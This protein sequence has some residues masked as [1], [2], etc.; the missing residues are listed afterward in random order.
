MIIEIINLHNLQS[1]SIWSFQ[2]C[3]DKQGDEIFIHLDQEGRRNLGGGWSYVNWKVW[4]NR[5]WIWEH[6]RMKCIYISAAKQ[7]GR[8]ICPEQFPFSDLLIFIPKSKHLIICD[9]CLVRWL[10]N[11][12]VTKHKCSMHWR[13][14]QTFMSENKPIFT[15]SVSIVLRS[16]LFASSILCSSC[17]TAP[18]P[19][20]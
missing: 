4:S 13:C 8:C 15:L 16:Y 3:C 9:T 11:H 6:K 5:R 17:L 12:M 2:E 19:T 10:P 7:Y 20:G 18:S 1:T 14:S